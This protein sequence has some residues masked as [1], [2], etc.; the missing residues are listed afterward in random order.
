MALSVKCTV[1]RVVIAPPLAVYRHA[2]DQSPLSGALRQR[3]PTLRRSGILLAIVTISLSTL[4]FHG[5]LSVQAATAPA[6]LNGEFFS[7]GG[8]DHAV[9]C[10]GGGTF[11]FTASGVATGP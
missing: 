10:N 5:V 4:A 7:A 3:R 11:T 2:D 8:G 1:S 9:A 6:T